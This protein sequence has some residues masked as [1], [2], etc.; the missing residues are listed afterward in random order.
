MPSANYDNGSFHGQPEQSVQS[1]SNLITKVH[2]RDKVVSLHDA[3]IPALPKDYANIHGVG[4]KDHAPVSG[5]KLILCDY[6]KGTGEAS[7]TV[8]V[9]L[10]PTLFPRMAHIAESNIG[11]YL[12]PIDGVWSKTVATHNMQRS[13]LNT[14]L[15]LIQGSVA[16]LAAAVKGEKTALAGFGRLLADNKQSLKEERGGQ[17]EMLR[18]PFTRDFQHTQTRVNSYK[19]GQDGFCPVS[20]LTIQRQGWYNG[21]ARKLPW[22]IKASNF[23]ARMKQSDKG[24]TSYDGTS[25]RNKQEAFIQISDED[26]YRACTAVSR[27]VN[28]WELSVGPAAVKKA[29]KIKEEERLT[30]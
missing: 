3:L 10:D 4:G 19:V 30:R 28:V 6:S 21:Q 24:T 16:V 25:V 12:A 8:S 17:E 22:T 14:M 15:N 13:M 29:I 11:E 26:W 7:V 18:I 27:F 5:I 20:V 9:N 1:L 23:E 2:G